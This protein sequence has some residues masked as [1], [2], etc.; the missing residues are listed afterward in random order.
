MRSR[1]AVGR[2]LPHGAIADD[3]ILDRLV[4]GKFDHRR[5]TGAT[6]TLTT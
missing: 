5:E 3:D 4:G 2:D 6:E 1:T